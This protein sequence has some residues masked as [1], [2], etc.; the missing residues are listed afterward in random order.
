MG[1]TIV[2]IGFAIWPDSPRMQS[3]NHPIKT[4]PTVHRF[5]RFSSLL[6]SS[7][8]P[9]VCMFTIIVANLRERG[10]VKLTKCV[11]YYA[12]NNHRHLETMCHDIENVHKELN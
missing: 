9:I 5:T 2:I 4:L 11:L 7:L 8:C 10:G 1:S 6:W 12:H 3:L